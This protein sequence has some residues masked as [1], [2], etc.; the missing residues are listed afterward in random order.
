VVAPAARRDVV[1]CA[2]RW[3]APTRPTPVSP[4]PR[5]LERR[6]SLPRSPLALV[7]APAS[8]R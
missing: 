5:A 6:L 2:P 7:N 4:R 8:V 3:R 1:P